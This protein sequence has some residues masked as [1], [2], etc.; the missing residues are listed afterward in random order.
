MSAGPLAK[1]H[2]TSP[3]SAPPT[4]SPP[5]LLRLPRGGWE[6][7]QG[8]QGLTQRRSPSPPQSSRAASRGGGGGGRWMPNWPDLHPTP[9][10]W[11]SL[12]PSSWPRPFPASPSADWGS[13]SLLLGPCPNMWL[14]LLT[15]S[16]ALSLTFF[17][18]F[19]PSPRAS[20][21]KFLAAGEQ[22]RSGGT[23]AKQET[24]ERDWAKSGATPE[25]RRRRRSC[26]NSN[27]L[28]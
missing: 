19:P 5:A 8:P 25:R 21:L 14:P 26:P 4:P 9:W 16:Q 1:L 24:V 12:N 13:L 10:P 28:F 18:S 11:P 22:L 2:R 23:K 27:C 17:F 6:G 15:S 20:L 7:P 3:S